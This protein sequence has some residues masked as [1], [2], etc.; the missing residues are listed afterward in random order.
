M[1]KRIS[2]IVLLMLPVMISLAQ[3]NIGQIEEIDYLKNYLFPAV[4]ITDDVPNQLGP[5]GT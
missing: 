5:G 2:F 1:R 4:L 3:I